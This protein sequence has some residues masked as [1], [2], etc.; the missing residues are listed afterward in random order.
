MGY[1]KRIVRYWNGTSWIKKNLRYWNGTSFE[2]G[3]SKSYTTPLVPAE[4]FVSDNNGNIHGLDG[5]GNVLWTNTELVGNPVDYLDVQNI[6]KHVIGVSTTQQKV[7][8]IDQ[9]GTTVNTRTGSEID[10]GIAID[11]RNDQ[12]FIVEFPIGLPTSRKLY[13]LNSDLTTDN[14]LAVNGQVSRYMFIDPYVV[15][16]FGFG[17][18]EPYIWIL[19]PDFATQGSYYFKFIGMDTLTDWSQNVDDTGEMLHGGVPYATVSPQDE[20]I[21]LFGGQ[22]ASFFIYSGPSFS[23]DG[24]MGG[25]GNENQLRV[26]KNIDRYLIEQ[27]DLRLIEFVAGIPSTTLPNYKTPT[28]TTWRPQSS[29]FGNDDNVIYI[30]DT[31]TLVKREWDTTNLVWTVPSFIDPMDRVVSFPG[32]SVLGN[33]FLP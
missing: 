1:D 14:S 4:V 24:S 6:S 13:R 12:I 23:T 29:C 25:A 7:V 27:N 18:A 30:T 32:Y 20:V 9:F 19:D 10:P 2:K 11:S 8:R 21:H 15:D 33:S 28:T 26:N 5:T 22:D 16:Y 3:Y 17:T 31:D